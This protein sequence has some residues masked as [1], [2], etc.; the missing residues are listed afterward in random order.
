MFCIE[1]DSCKSKRIAQDRIQREK[2]EESAKHAQELSAAEI[3]ESVR[4][5][6]DHLI[7]QAKSGAGVFLHESIYLP[8]DSVVAEQRL[9]QGF[10][11]NQL[12]SLGWEG[13]RIVGIIPKTVGISLKNTSF[14]LETGTIWGA[15]LGGNVAG[16]YVLLELEVNSSRAESLRPII[17]THIERAMSG[18]TNDSANPSE[19]VEPLDIMSQGQ[20]YRN[21]VRIVVSEGCASTSLLQRRLGIGHG[22]AA[23][24]IDMMYENNIVGPAQGSGPR[25]V[26]V[27]QN[28]VDRIF[29][30]EE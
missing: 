28:Y 21:A 23:E 14:G 25:E 29:G 10:D 11:I 26:L 9:A 5:A 16:A 19:D 20:M 2:M 8:V 17:R 18:N 7:E 22:R 3:A 15:G 12:R 24:L 4:R 13:W 6:V 30:K 27:G 1:C